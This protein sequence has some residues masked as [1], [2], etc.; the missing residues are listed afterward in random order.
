VSRSQRYCR[1]CF[2]L[3]VNGWHIS[4]EGRCRT[5]AMDRAIAMMA[6]MWPPDPEETP[7]QIAE[8]MDRQAAAERGLDEAAHSGA[9]YLLP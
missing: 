2:R 9:G 7:A 6:A 4:K 8:R 5:C 1:E 3:A